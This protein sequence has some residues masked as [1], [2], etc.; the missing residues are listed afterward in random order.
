MHYVGIATSVHAVLCQCYTQAHAHPQTIR[1][2]RTSRAKGG[3]CNIWTQ[4]FS[5]TIPPPPP[6]TKPLNLLHPIVTSSVCILSHNNVTHT[7][8]IVQQ[9]PSL[10]IVYIYILKHCTLYLDPPPSPHTRLHPIVTSN[11][12]VPSHNNATHTPFTVQQYLSLC[13]IYYVY[14]YTHSSTMPCIWTQ[15]FSPPPPPPPHQ[16][17][18]QL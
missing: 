9:Y 11:V 15:V 12:C 14:I 3:Y 5:L 4:V 2:Q 6:P 13:I 10:Y 1:G 7:P 18:A 8:F 17:S 16:L